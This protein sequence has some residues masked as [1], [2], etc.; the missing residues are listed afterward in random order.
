MCM[1]I[2]EWR[3]SDIR[4]SLKSCEPQGMGAG[5]APW[6][7]GRAEPSREPFPKNFV[8][9]NLSQNKLEEQ[10]APADLYEW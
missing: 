7:S 3:T 8:E 5:A 1:S 10:D 2:C 4:F 9:N 6:S